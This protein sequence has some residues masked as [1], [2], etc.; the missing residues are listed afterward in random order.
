MNLLSRCDDRAMSIVF[1]ILEAAKP[2]PDLAAHLGLA[3]VHRDL[4]GYRQLVRNFR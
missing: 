3:A 2:R 4:M 1:L